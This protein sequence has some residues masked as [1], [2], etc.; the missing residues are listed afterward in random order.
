MRKQVVALF[1]AFRHK[2]S[3]RTRIASRLILGGVYTFDAAPNAGHSVTKKTCGARIAH[4]RCG[5]VDTLDA[6]FKSPSHART[7]VFII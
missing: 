6:H 7:K 2:S 5:R 4:R 3:F 1:A